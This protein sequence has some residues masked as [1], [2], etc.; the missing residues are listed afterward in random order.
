M[1]GH[2][3]RAHRVHGRCTRARGRQAEH[4]EEELSAAAGR[5]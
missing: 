1:H 2:E 3:A 5:P 4:D